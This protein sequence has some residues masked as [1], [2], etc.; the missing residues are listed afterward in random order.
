MSDTKPGAVEVEIVRPGTATEKPT[1]AN[2]QT[3]Q[4]DDTELDFGSGLGP[5]DQE[6]EEDLPETTPE[7]EDKPEGDDEPS[8][9][10]LPDYDPD[11][12]ETKAAYDKKYFTDGGK[13]NLQVLSAEYFTNAEKGEDK[14]GLNAGTYAY[15]EDTLGLD[16]A[17]V[18]EIERGQLALR[19]QATQAFYTK[20]GGKEGYEAALAW[21]KDG[22]YS[23][24]QRQRYNALLAKGGAD[25]EDAAEAL[26]ARYAKATGKAAPEAGRRGPPRGRRPSSPQRD[27][28]GSSRTG[29]GEGGPKMTQAAYGQAWRG[30]LD[31]V[32]AAKKSGDKAAIR[33]AEAKRDNLRAKARRQGLV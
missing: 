15:L 28:T 26:M 21:A 11:N 7:D 27:V 23:E 22:G 2:P 18:Q 24:A 17:A 30:V 3:V 4:S 6:D 13:V 8:E 10:D 19:D 32:H 12:E 33:A 25:F 5:E 9:G 14:A 20:V 29:S 31:E 1:G 16:K